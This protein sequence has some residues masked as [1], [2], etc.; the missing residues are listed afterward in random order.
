MTVLLPTDWGHQ[1]CE[2]TFS[3]TLNTSTLSNTVQCM[4]LAHRKKSQLIVWCVIITFIRFRFVGSQGV[5]WD[6]TPINFLLYG[7]GHFTKILNPFLFQII[8]LYIYEESFFRLVTSICCLIQILHL[9]FAL[10]QTSN[11]DPS[12]LKLG[13]LL[14]EK[15][16]KIASAFYPVSKQRAISLVILTNKYLRIQS[17]L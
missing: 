11:F 7:R 3:S 2:S 10:L 15:G 6:K 14:K 17:F 9:N 12:L 5:V 13:Y 16:W 1:E 4:W 8:Y